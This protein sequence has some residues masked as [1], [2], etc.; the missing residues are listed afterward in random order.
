ML[1]QL[2]E[3]LS[4]FTE[5]WEE[6]LRKGRSQLG[7][8]LENAE[9]EECLALIENAEDLSETTDTGSLSFDITGSGEEYEINYAPSGNS[10]S[11]SRDQDSGTP[12]SQNYRG[13]DELIETL[14]NLKDGVLTSREGMVESLEIIDSSGQHQIDI[15][16]TIRASRIENAIVEELD[17]ATLSV[18]LYFSWAAFKNHIQEANLAE[19]RQ[20]LLSEEDHTESLVVIHSLN[21]FVQGNSLGVYGLGWLASEGYSSTTAGWTNQ[22]EKIRRQTLIQEPDQRFLPPSFFQFNRTSNEEW[23]EEVRQLFYPHIAVFS[24]LSIANTAEFQNGSTWNVRIQGRQ[25]IEGEIT[26]TSTNNLSVTS[27]EDGEPVELT[28]GRVDDLYSLYCWVYDHNAD[29][30]ISVVR[31]VATLYARNIVE[32]VTD[33]DEIESSAESNRQYYMKES[34]DEFF[35]F[36]Q[37]LMESAFET[38]SR[39]AD[40]R[41]ELMNDL[42]RDLFRTFA[43]ITAI[44]ATA[45]FRLSD[46]L[47]LV[48]T[49]L[50]V[51]S[52]LLVYSS[53]T[54]RR[55][56]GIRTQFLNLIETQKNQADFYTDF[57]DEDELKDRGIGSDETCPWWGT[58]F[59]WWWNLRNKEV[60]YVRLRCALAL[61]LL[62]YYVLI[63]MVVGI[64]VIL[65]LEA[66]R[67]TDVIS[68]IP[69]SDGELR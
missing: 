61:D 68:A 19:T 57:F 31:N 22:M 51:S 54:L 40:L 43:F 30:R 15:G 34:V 8:T 52:V 4:S 50:G 47:P 49:Y 39:F 58:P 5:S 48:P 45:I 42:S 38:Q 28:K 11:G 17:E 64:A 66:L 37:E 67:V 12:I 65:A 24:I 9:L 53:V 6:Y 36:R 7:L 10:V 13:N 21:D 1:E 63:L 60:E 16:C 18:N 32:L 69:V 27:D 3:A 20:I 14:T 35:E 59:R 26:A 44:A 23:Q 33:A 41:S 62:M 55:V 46:L 29:N 56:R 2:D 25:Y